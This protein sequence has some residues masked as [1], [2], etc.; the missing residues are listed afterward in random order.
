MGKVG[1][2]RCGVT[3][4]QRSVGVSEFANHCA[5]AALERRLYCQQTWTR[6]PEAAMFL[7]HWE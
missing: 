2:P 1:M 7:C 6:Y 3:E 4:T 5:P